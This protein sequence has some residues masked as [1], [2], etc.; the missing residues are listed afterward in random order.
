M[1]VICVD[2]D[3]H[4]F[5]PPTGLEMLRIYSIARFTQDPKGGWGYKLR[6]VDGKEELPYAYGRSRFVIVKPKPVK[7]TTPENY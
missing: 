7:Q 3:D 5:G 4:G 1:N 6:K 2:V